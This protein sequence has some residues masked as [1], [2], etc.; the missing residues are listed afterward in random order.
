MKQYSI[1]VWAFTVW[2]DIDQMMHSTNHFQNDKS[3]NVE[4]TS[5][6]EEGW[7]PYNVFSSHLLDKEKKVVHTCDRA[8][9]FLKDRCC[10]CQNGFGREGA[11]RL[12]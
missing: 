11:I 2:D 6:I 5:E 8:R 12:G 4:W 1:N 10:L 7:M 9:D 3:G